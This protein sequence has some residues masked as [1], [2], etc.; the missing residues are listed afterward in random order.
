M[1]LYV[2]QGSDGLTQPIL[3]SPAVTITWTIRA[4][5]EQT[6]SLQ[7]HGAHHYSNVRGLL[8]YLMQCADARCQ[9]IAMFQGPS[10]RAEHHDSSA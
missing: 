4:E 2:F 1:A 3:S 10:R 6:P 9:S 8:L 5:V 7:L